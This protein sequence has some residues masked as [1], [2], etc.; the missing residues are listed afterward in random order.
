MKRTSRSVV[1]CPVS[2]HVPQ[3]SRRGHQAGDADGG[4]VDKP[5]PERKV[6]PRIYTN[7]VSFKV[8]GA[9]LRSL[10]VVAGTKAP[11]R[12]AATFIFFLF[13]NSPSGHIW[14]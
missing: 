13:F 14:Q 8:R 1:E 10:P 2:L 7:D 6:N 11:M 12:I 5:T 4:K 9:P 3:T